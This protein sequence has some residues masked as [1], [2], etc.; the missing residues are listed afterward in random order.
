VV[1]SSGDKVNVRV[2]LALVRTGLKL[3]TLLPTDAAATLRQHGVDL[4]ELSGM[5]GEAL[6]EALRELQVDVDTADGGT[7][8]VYCE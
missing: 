5:K 8:R 2:P 3:S 7:V 4:S 6:I 1:D